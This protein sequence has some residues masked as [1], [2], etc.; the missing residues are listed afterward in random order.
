MPLI[1]KNVADPTS[2]A[3]PSSAADALRLRR[4]DS[5]PR[6]ANG[7][8]NGKTP[9]VSSSKAPHALSAANETPLSAPPVFSRIPRDRKN[10]R[11]LT[12]PKLIERLGSVE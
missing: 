4:E 11:D 7:V 10:V 3:S 5:W 12:Q 6:P 9:V 2:A 8:E 1:P